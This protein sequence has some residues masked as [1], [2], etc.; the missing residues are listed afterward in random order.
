MVDEDLS[1][2]AKKIRRKLSEAGL[3]GS[4][5]MTPLRT[6][7][8]ASPISGGLF[9]ANSLP[10]PDSPTTSK[11]SFVEEAS[12][13]YRTLI[14]VVDE[15]VVVCDTYQAA[16]IYDT[17]L[18]SFLPLYACAFALHTQS[19]HHSTSTL[20]TVSTQLAYCFEMYR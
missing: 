13:D 2:R 11:Q 15:V 6:S 7:P 18:S 10:L 9:R 16:N 8:I 4:E 17:F 19:L 1:P 20:T 3:A 5:D 12:I 14:S